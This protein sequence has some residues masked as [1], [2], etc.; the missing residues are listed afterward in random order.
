MTATYRTVVA[1]L[2][3]L[4]M[5]LYLAATSIPQQNPQTYDTGE[6]NGKTAIKYLGSA[7]RNGGKGARIYY[8]GSCQNGIGALTSDRGAPS[9]SFPSVDVQP[10]SGDGSRLAA[11]RAIFRNEKTTKVEERPS[12][13]I[14]IT[15]GEVPDAMLQTRLSPLKLTPIQQYNA[16]EAIEAIEGTDEVQ[17]AMRTLGLHLQI[18]FHGELLVPPGAKGYPHLPAS[19][20]SVTLDEAL[21]SI[22]IKFKSIVAYGVCTAANG[23]DTFRIDNF[24]A[25][26]DPGGAKK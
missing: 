6:P 8:R 24:Y 13:I 26:G 20:S 18:L 21:D 2:S 10:P 1:T 5:C 4:F 19:I 7:L 11:V 14:A 12:G 25:G 22:A 9:V 16:F 15:I 3:I 17:V 23:E